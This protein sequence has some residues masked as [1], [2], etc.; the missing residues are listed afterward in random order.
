MEQDV[1]PQTTTASMFLDEAVPTRR[2]LPHLRG[3]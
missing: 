3:G 2:D 1:L